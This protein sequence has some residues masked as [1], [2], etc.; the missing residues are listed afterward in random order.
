MPP[1]D[2]DTR[3]GSEFYTSL[4]E[5]QDMLKKMNRRSVAPDLCPHRYWDLLEPHLSCALMQ[6]YNTCMDQGVTPISWSG[7]LI[8]PI[9]KPK[10]SGTLMASHRPVQLMLM[11]AKLFSKLLLRNLATHVSIS[12]LQ[13]ARQGV[14]PPILA[15]QQFVAHTRD[16]H[17]SG[18]MIFVDIS[19][20]YDDIS[21]QLLLGP[22]TPSAADSDIIYSGFRNAG[23][24]HASASA[25]QQYLIEYPHHI[26]NERVPPQLLKVLKHWIVSPWFQLPQ[27]HT[28]GENLQA[29]QPVLKATKGIRQGDCLSTFLFCLFFD[30]ALNVI[31]RFVCDNT[32][33]IDF[34]RGVDAGDQPSMCTPLGELPGHDALTLIAYADDLLIPVANEDP[35]VLVR[36]LQRLLQCLSD[37]FQRYQLRL[38]CGPQKTEMCLHLASREAKSIMQF[39][40]NQ[41]TDLA[42][43]SEIPETATQT[44]RTSPHIAFNKGIVRIV[45]SYNYLGRWS[46]MCVSPQQDM[47]VQRAKAIDSF[48]K[49]QAVLTSRRYSLSTRLFLFKS[50]VRCHLLQN[51]ASYC[52]WPKKS[53]SALNGTYI[54]LLKRIVFL[55]HDE[56]FYH[57]SD[58]EL[59]LYL[60]EPTLEQL[61]D[62]RIATALPKTC[63]SPNTQIRA[64]LSGT[65]KSSVWTSWLAVLQR[66]LTRSPGALGTLPP[67]T[68][69][70]FQVWLS[71]MVIA[72]HNWK[73][74]AQASTGCG[75]KPLVDLRKVYTLH[76]DQVQERAN[77]IP[78]A[79]DIEMDAPVEE[80]EVTAEA[81]Q[82][83]PCPYCDRFFMPGRGLLAHKMKTHKVIPPLSLRTR[84]TNCLACGSQLGTRSRLLDHLRRKLSCALWTLDAVEPMTEAEYYASVS[85]LNAV[86]H[87]LDRDL[88]R[89]GPIPMI[90]GKFSSQCV[91]PLDPFCDSELIP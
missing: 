60:G 9:C 88:P 27:T 12:W 78:R 22:D 5:V 54:L 81:G 82:L 87:L 15:S 85:K 55:E 62:L 63:A 52:S 38:N 23:F 8:V 13:F 84:S 24:D 4:H 14:S 51:V 74:L 69:H 57:V 56:G 46:S 83:V 32:A 2:L 39:L 17:L 49:H 21:H 34:T 80:D 3:A 7:S 25:T 19:A 18:A 29:D 45:S 40:R 61:C 28:H 26:L 68:T 89:T 71:M 50:L 36:Q 6:S 20:A 90:D 44:T 30:F 33:A 77:P 67:P 35:H 70:T 37:T 16:H 75:T 65:T 91:A 59:L 64:A 72:G 1:G 47:A 86:D 42:C 53:V 58:E 66:M 31:H 79:V 76:S 43:T 11:E 10:K 41:G 48:H 73:A